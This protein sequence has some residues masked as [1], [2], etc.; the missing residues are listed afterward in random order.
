MR[1]KLEVSREGWRCGDGCCSE[2]WLE[3]Q[4]RVTH[5]GQHSSQHVSAY[6]RWDGSANSLVRQ[7]KED[8]KAQ[9][10]VELT[11]ANTEFDVSEWDEEEEGVCS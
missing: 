8:A 11:E 7:L 5:E 10:G 9:F 1:F 2:S 3:G 4:V 6:D